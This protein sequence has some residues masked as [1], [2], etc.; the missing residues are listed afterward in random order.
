MT[1]SLPIDHALLLPPDVLQPF[2]LRFRRDDLHVMA[3]FEGHPEYEAVEAMIQVR[4]DRGKSIR[5]IITRHDQSQIDHVND[6]ALLVA[7]RGTERARCRRE[8]DLQLQSSTEGRRARLEFLSSA[9]ERV[10]LDVVTVGEPDVKRGGLSDPGGHSSNSSLPLMW[11][12]ASTLAGPGTKVTIDGVEYAVPVKVRAGAFVAHEGYYTER[13]SMGVIRTG[14]VSARLLKKP[15]RLEVGAEWLFQHDEYQTA[16]RLTTL[17]AGGT[18]QITRLEGSGEMITAHAIE[19][20]LAVTRI[21]LPAEAGPTDGLV[22][23]F[24]RDAGFGLS[25]EG[26]Q[27]IVAGRVH[28]AEGPHGAVISLR[29]MQPGWAV[30]RVV[31][32]ACLR[33]GD[34]MK[35]VTTIGP[36]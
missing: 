25:I 31:R 30:D 26:Q 9:G 13:H 8:I 14:T 6:D 11:R 1:N 10:V 32:V 22:L 23:A 4:A 16:Y 24:D 36:A 7:L 27:D 21:S 29:P 17:G 12:G 34:Q 28:L 15:H 3:F 33:D 35:F 2:P 18:L 20:R 19:D 5:A